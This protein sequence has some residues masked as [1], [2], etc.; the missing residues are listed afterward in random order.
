[1]QAE[2]YQNGYQKLKYQNHNI[3]KNLNKR[4]SEIINQEDYWKIKYKFTKDLKFE[5]LMYENIFFDFLFKNNF[6]K[7][8][9]EITSKKLYLTNVLVRICLKGLSYMTWHRDTYIKKNKIIGP[10]MPC[11]KLM[12]Y[13]NLYNKKSKEISL[14]KSSH[15][16]LLFTSFHKYLSSFNPNKQDIYNDNDSCTL[17]DTTILHKAISSL[18]DLPRPR[19]IFNF[20][21]EETINAFY[22]SELNQFYI[23][24]YKNSIN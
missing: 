17:I 13:P 23:N 15:N 21:T 7:T 8:I 18:S 24:R 12:V 22:N 19:I 16:R 9:N 1:M 5:Y 4:L 14:I 3:V 10:F 2:F 6:Q 11:Y 20:S